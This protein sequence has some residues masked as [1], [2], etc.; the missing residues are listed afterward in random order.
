MRSVAVKRLPNRWMQRGPEE[1]KAQQP[2][3]AERP[4][5]DLGIV[6]YLN[7]ISFPFACDLLGVCR[8]EENSYA[9]TSLATSGNLFHWCDRDPRPGPSREQ[10]MYPIVRQVFIGI[11][12]LHELG[13]A[14]RDISLENILLTDRA[15]GGLQVKII[16]FA[17][18]TPTR[19]CCQEARGKPSYQAPEMHGDAEYDAFLADVFSLGVVVFAMAFKDY[20]WASTKSDTCALFGYAKRCGL[21]K[22][23]EKRRLRNGAPDEHLGDVVSPALA[24]L[25]E[26]LMKVEPEQRSTLGEACFNTLGTSASAW[27]M[28]WLQGNSSAGA[29]SAMRRSGSNRLA[30]G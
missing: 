2:L 15:G 26:G 4:W 1:F 8:D 9:I 11:T 10:V 24:G 27:S 13:I 25:L 19:M 20:P 3:A 28:E 14:H 17:M 18:A 22:F 21:R 29:C 7:S 6:K 16:D 12:Y 5:C 23:L 30:G